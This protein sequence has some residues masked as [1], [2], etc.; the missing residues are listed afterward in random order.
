MQCSGTRPSCNYCS[1]HG[2]D[3]VYLSIDSQETASAAFKRKYAEARQETDVHQRLY[4]LLQSASEAEAQSILH[5]IRANGDIATVVQQAEVCNLLQLGLAQEMR[6]PYEFSCRTAMPQHLLLSTNPYLDSEI[7]EATSANQPVASEPA[8]P[9][10]L[11]P[12][13]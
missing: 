11:W 4:Q 7:Y 3:C 13:Y 1:G 10:D 8:G 6:H 2:I 5:M 9:G 12:P